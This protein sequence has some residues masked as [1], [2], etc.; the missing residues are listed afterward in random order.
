[1]I[2]VKNMSRLD[3][4]IG[5]KVLLHVVLAP[6]GFIILAISNAIYTAFIKEI[7][8]Y[9]MLNITFSSGLYNLFVYAIFALIIGSWL[10]LFKRAV[11]KR[12]AENLS[13]TLSAIVTLFIGVYGFFYTGKLINSKTDNLYFYNSEIPKCIEDINNGNSVISCDGGYTIFSCQ[14]I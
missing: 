9:K 4:F 11:F 14:L 8:F 7:D 6:V 13:I 2:K 10:Y 12:R 3:K 5:K 1:M